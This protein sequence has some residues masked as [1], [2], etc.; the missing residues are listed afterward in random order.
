MTGFFII[1]FESVGGINSRR[2]KIVGNVFENSEQVMRYLGYDVR[3]F[4]NCLNA[5]SSYFYD[6]SFDC[7]FIGGM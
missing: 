4:K 2:L 6:Q 1:F 7:F 5:R 3:I